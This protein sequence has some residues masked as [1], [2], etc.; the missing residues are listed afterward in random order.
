MPLSHTPESE[1]P[2]TP[3]EFIEVANLGTGKDFDHQSLK[4]F[5][6]K[7]GERGLT[8]IQQA[9][10]SVFELTGFEPSE[11]QEVAA[12]KDSPNSNEYEA[13][14]KAIQRQI[15][16]VLPFAQADLVDKYFS[17]ADLQIIADGI[18][19]CNDDAELVMMALQEKL[20]NEAD[21]YIKQLVDKYF[22]GNESLKIAEEVDECNDAA[23]LVMMTFNDKMPP[24]V[25]YDA[26][27]K[28]LIM[29]FLG[30]IKNRSSIAEVCALRYMMKIYKEGILEAP[31]GEKAACDIPK[32]LVSWHE[33]ITYKT[34]RT[35]FFDTRPVDIEK[36]ELVQVTDLQCGKTTVWDNLGKG[37]RIYF[38]MESRVK[39]DYS[40]LTKA[41]RYNCYIGEKDFDRNGIR[42]LFKTRADCED[43]FRLYGATVTRKLVGELCEM[44]ADSINDDDAA[45]I[46]ERINNID[47]SVKT[48][49]VKDSLEG[50]EFNGSGPSSSKK[51][52]VYKF[53]ISIE[54]ADGTTHHVEYQNFLPNGYA[55]EKYRR[56]LSQPEYHV[57][58]FFREG[59]DELMFS[60]K[61]YSGIDREK[62]YGEA[63]DQAHATIWNGQSATMPP[64]SATS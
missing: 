17:R 23:E 27:R 41:F 32:Y 34:I 35:E 28:L 60:K 62:A 64:P 29:K 61:Y 7:K 51:L 30:E 53:K 44:Y 26:A 18:D 56:G 48:Y 50:N 2:I 9:R 1:P 39:T 52:E 38:A 55:D 8:I 11:L 59:V 16:D 24:K 45:E 40:S 20:G 36:D 15:R 54:V 49:Q 5:L 14:K 63:L 37:R 46:Q 57:D 22:S 19:E 6:K 12:K 25:K 3:R 58:R 43:F 33:P 13:T 21:E 31:D 10:D 47:R 4:D 42:K